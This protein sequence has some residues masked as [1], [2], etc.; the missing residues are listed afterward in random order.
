MKL[1]RFK[2]KCHSTYLLS[3]SLFIICYSVLNY[4]LKLTSVRAPDRLFR[5]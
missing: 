3:E 5:N 2:K 4:K 1:V